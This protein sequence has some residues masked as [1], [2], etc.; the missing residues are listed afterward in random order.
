MCTVPKIFDLYNT[1]YKY[2]NF[3]KLNCMKIIISKNESIVFS[4]YEQT[5]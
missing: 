5:F 3:Y 1:Q 4:I 2:A